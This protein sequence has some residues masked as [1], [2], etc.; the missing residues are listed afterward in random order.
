MGGAMISPER[1]RRY[2]HCANAPDEL[3]RD[4]AMIAQERTF[5]PD[6]RLFEEGSP[7]DNFMFLEAGEIDIVYR[8]ADN[9]E[10]VVDSL[11]AGD[12]LGWSSLLDPY[13][14]STSGIARQDGVLIEI[15]GRGLQKLCDENPTYGYQLMTYVARTLQSRLLASLVQLAAQS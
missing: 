15:D 12:S 10:V 1:L 3:L 6:E 13:T 11:V 4:V 2:P 9:R 14:F 8:L 7:A 5:V